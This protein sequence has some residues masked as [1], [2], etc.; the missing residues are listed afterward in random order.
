MFILKSSPLSVGNSLLPEEKFNVM[1]RLHIEPD[2][3]TAK[4]ICFM[5]EKHKCLYFEVLAS[6]Q[7]NF[8]FFLKVAGVF[9]EKNKQFSITWGT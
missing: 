4:Q 3:L 7:S 1:K 9:Q 2:L 5:T 6:L 8:H